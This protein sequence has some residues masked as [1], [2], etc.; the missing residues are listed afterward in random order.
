MDLERIEREF[1]RNFTEYG[2]LGASLSVWRDGERV[3]NLAD[4]WSDK[5]RQGVWDD[6]TLVPVYSATKGPAASVLL[7]LLDENGLTPESRVC[8]VWEEFPNQQASFAELMS[9]QCGLAALDEVASVFE[10]DAVIDAIEGQSANWELGSGHGYHPRT[11]GFLLDKPVRL[12]AGKSLGEV[13]RE[14]VA[15]PLGLDFWIGLPEREHYRVATLYPGKADKE[16]LQSGFYKEFN[17]AGS[18][19]RRAF[20]SPRGL[21]GVHEMNTAKA[22]QSGLPAMGGVATA[23]AMAKFY[24]ACIGRIECFSDDVREWMGSSQVMGDDMVLCTPTHFTCGFQKDPL[25]GGGD[26]IRGHY[27][28]FLGAFGHPGAGGSH[29]FGD[30]ECGVSFAY[31]MNQMDLAVLPGAKSLNVIRA[32]YSSEWLMGA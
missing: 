10:F 6:E 28:P 13:W 17:E 16:E 30:P 26:K 22:W 32:L 8:Q 24:Q 18:L 1:Q 5:G 14:R 31:T 23:D 3:V 20:G 15:D 25:G 27:G 7:M 2:E 29:A 12:L 4:G 9:H 19:V 11:F 21:H